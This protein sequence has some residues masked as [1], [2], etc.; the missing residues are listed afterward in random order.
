MFT[1]RIFTA[2]SQGQ[3][4]STGFGFIEEEAI[5]RA[6]ELANLNK[7]VRVIKFH[8]PVPIMEQLLLGGSQS[9]K[10]SL[11]MSALLDLASP[12]AYYL[13]TFMPGVTAAEPLASRST[14][15]GPQREQGPATRP[16][17]EDLP[18]STQR[19]QR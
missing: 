18:Q 15:Q 4:T 19:P 5:D 16:S 9:R 7:D 3:P 12:R 1:G 13:C 14:R 8:R 2:T 17:E 11:D 6:I 10:Q